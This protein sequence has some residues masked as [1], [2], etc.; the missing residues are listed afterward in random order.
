MRRKPLFLL[1]L[2]V[3]LC[4]SAQTNGDEC[5]K[6]C[7]CA[8][9]PVQPTSKLLL[10]DYSSLSNSTTITP[11]ASSNFNNQIANIRSLFI[12][13]DGSHFRFPDAYFKSLTA[14]H[15]L[16]IVG[17]HTTHFSVKLFEDLSA[18]RTLELDQISTSTGSFEMTEDVLMPLARLEKFS[19]TRSQN[20]ELPQRLLCSLPHLQVLNLSSNGIPT[21][22]REETCVAQQLLIVDLS[23]NQLSSIEQFLRGIPAI[24]QISIA[25][26]QVSQFD[27]SSATPFLQQLDAESNRITDLE[28]LP[29]TVV[30][31]NLAGNLLKRIP[32]SVN[33]L[34]NLVALN[35]SRN[36]I[37]ATNSTILISPELEMLDASHNNLE[38]L[39]SEWLQKCEKR[40]AHL[41]LEHNQIEKIPSGVLS[42]ATNL[43]T[44]DLSSNRL[45]V[46]GDDILPENSKI[47]NLRLANNS[48]EVL[49]PLSLEGLKLEFLDLSKNRL[50]EV[51]AAIGKVEQLKKVDLSHNQIGKV[52][53]YVLNK[54]K[55]LHT[56]DLSNNQLQSIGPYIFSDS[57][58]LHSL[59]VSNNEISLLF[60][61]AF[62][63][64][65]KLRKISM[66]NNK[67]K[68]LDEGL[69]E[70][71]ALRRL[72]V[73]NNQIVVLKWSALPESLEVLI[74]DNNDVNLLTASPT[75]IQLKTVSLSNNRITVLN[76][77]QIPNSLESF[78][79]SHNRLGRLG[80]S[81]LAEKSQLRKL[82][83][84]GNLLTVIPTDSVR[85]LEGVHQIKV[86]LAENPLICDCQMGWMLAT[87]SVAD[88]TR[89]I[90]ILDPQV[91]TCMH[92]VDNHQIPLEKLTK[93]DL[94]CPY[95]SICEPEC[96]CC[97]YGNCDCKSVCPASCRCFRDDQFN[98]NIVRCAGN[99]TVTPKREFIVSELPVTATEI[100]LSGVTLPQ[101]RTHSFIGRL[102]LQRLH[103]NGTGLR[104]IQ[105]KAFH[106]LPSLK[107]LDLSDNSLL[108][109]NGEEFLKCPEVSQLFLNGNR[110]STLSRGMFE[111]LPNLKYLT[112]HNNSFEDIPHVLS[113]TS[114]AKVSFSGNPLRC[115]CSNKVQHHHHHADS[116]FWEHNAA[117]WFSHHRDLVVDFGKVECWENVT[118]AFQ[119][120]DTT[121]LS[122]YPP[123][124]GNDVFMMPIEEFLRDYNSSICVPFS[125]GF[126]GQDP[127]NSIIFVIITFAIAILLI[128]LVVLAVSF[129]RKSH[130]AI[131]QRRYKASSLNCS[132]SAGS[133][134]LPI[135]L[136]SYH[137][138][139][140]YSKKDEKMVIDQLCRP[141]E[142]EDYQ[143][144]L[145]HRDGP[146]Y[147]SNLHAISDELIAQMDSSQCL[148]LVLTKHFL[149]NEWKTLQIKT[150]H[151]LFAKNRS[152]R[153]IAVLGDGVDANLLDDELGQIL[154]KHTRIEMRSHLFWTLLH[155]SLPS[156]LPLPPND[157]SS[158]LYS[159]IYGI[160]PSDVV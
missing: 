108:S 45:R 20:I 117:E 112:L 18:L 75:K 136:L 46:F 134:P 10:C 53:Q 59:D 8:P 71:N 101:L 149:E 83:L 68:S 5:P 26:N 22:R 99:S 19:L 129:V 130:D 151:Q 60:K 49:E 95:Q 131:N 140:S 124:M 90:Q 135:P 73:S 70:A 55:Q 106:T 47:G 52:Y 110:F 81:A 88:K 11:I 65:P 126:F 16:R 63:R 104:S 160:V 33:S 32:D 111:K 80:K 61:D 115:D 105:P 2:L 109:L 14:L 152:K 87:S 58:E 98:I 159:D 145:L 116:P 84:K 138:F 78:D 96:I 56:V 142:D 62:A 43:Q 123:N 137:A 158:Q 9:D 97:Q 17:C 107:T 150:S 114:L 3:L 4:R 148:I 132:T 50:T 27:A 141:L 34:P 57:S 36:T 147:N 74:A 51:P 1:L 120:N 85:I 38:T 93:K 122:A 133:S 54:I 42:N 67:I 139:V 40:L 121:V 6:F 79:V 76:A 100:I 44:L 64:C 119:T 31:V 157:D 155:S 72:D 69:T 127:Q 12:N 23:R 29:E 125:S 77:E 15:H 25:H 144:C 48:L 94:L 91:A 66:R 86:E 30:H 128:I 156:R 154:R 103:I 24:R 21:L 143:L 37:E 92:P 102:R 39:P 41:H 7:K 13:C 82:I 113:T 118:K 35:V 146:T 153:V 28:S 89:R